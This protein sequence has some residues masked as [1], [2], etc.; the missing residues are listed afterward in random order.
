MV[1]A[2][3]R[4]VHEFVDNMTDPRSNLLFDGGKAYVELHAEHDLPAPW[5]AEFW[6]YRP[7]EEEEIRCKVEQARALRQ[8]KIDSLL[9]LPGVLAAVKAGELRLAEVGRASAADR[10]DCIMDLTKAAE[11]RDELRKKVGGKGVSWSQTRT[12]RSLA[13]S[14][15]ITRSSHR[16]AASS[17]QPAASNQ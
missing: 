5:T 2:K 17:Q 8:Q 12:H 7:A 1:R 9:I 16:P 3:N 10:Q 6:V 14:R 13:H 11:K 4:K 15:T